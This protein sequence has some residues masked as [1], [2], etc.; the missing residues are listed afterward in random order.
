MHE[1][2]VT[3][4][5]IDIAIDK[6][7]ES[8]AQR[9]VKINLVVGEMSSVVDDYIQFYFDF[10]SK[11]TLAAGAQLCFRKVPL[12]VK[13]RRCGEVFKPTEQPWHCPK[14]QK[15]DAEIVAGNEFYVE[16]LEVE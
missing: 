13:C 14:C 4:E 15:W 8:H 11:D 3:Q 10:M 2:S 5:I 6:A 16:S 12:E 7:K 9:V 1:L